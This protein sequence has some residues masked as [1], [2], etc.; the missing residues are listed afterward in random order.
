MEQKFQQKQRKQRKA[1]TF[2]IQRADVILNFETKVD[3]ND[4][5]SL[6]DAS[7]KLGTDGTLYLLEQ[8][9]NSLSR[10][11]ETIDYNALLKELTVLEENIELLHQQGEELTQKKDNFEKDFL[12]QLQELQSSI[13]QIPMMDAENKQIFF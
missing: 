10:E 4:I 8:E 6:R 13:E 7:R 11:I 3:K 12:S 2:L 9:V 5:I 1:T